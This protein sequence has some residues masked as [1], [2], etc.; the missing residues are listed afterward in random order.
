MKRTD[1]Y[2]CRFTSF[3]KTGVVD[4]QKVSSLGLLA[5]PS[6]HSVTVNHDFHW[7]WI[8]IFQNHFAAS[9]NNQQSVCGHQMTTMSEPTLYPYSAD[10]L[11]E[12]SFFFFYIPVKNSYAHFATA[13]PGFFFFLIWR[14]WCLSDLWHGALDTKVVDHIEF[15]KVYFN[16]T[17]SSWH[18]CVQT[19]VFSVV[20]C[21]K[22]IVL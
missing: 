3:I 8:L 10:P 18:K 17:V 13:N 9:L 5:L 20:E 4:K 14:V 2:K 6:Q 15:P 12:L 7:N 19:Q 16:S 21:V 11:A 1:W 22:T